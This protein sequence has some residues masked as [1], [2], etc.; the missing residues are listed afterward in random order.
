MHGPKIVR[1]IGS[2]LKDL[3]DFPEEPRREVGNA[4]YQA[5]LGEKHPKSKPLRG[6]HGA[7]VL[8]IMEDFDTGAYRAV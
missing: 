5:Q 8:E 2:S 3:R 6:F 7:S 1:W 4:L